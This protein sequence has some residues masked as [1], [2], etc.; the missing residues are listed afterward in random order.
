[1]RDMKA[2]TRTLTNG[3]SYNSPLRERQSE[4][5]REAILDA[6]ATELA[7][8][9]LQELNVPAVARRA[10]VAV[11]TVYRYFPTRDALLDAAEQRLDDTVAPGA[12]PASPEDLPVMAERVFREFDSNEKMILAQWATA[13]GRDVR[14]RGRRRRVSVYGDVLSTITS[15][16]PRA[17]ARAAHAI[18]SYLMSSWMW[19]TLR[20][21]FNMSG[22]QSGKAAAWALRV[23]ID[24]L[25]RRN[26]TTKQP[27][28]ATNNPQN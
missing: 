14:A 19:K 12:S 1:M 13:L 7:E 11:R 28:P 16:L 18:V 9:G 17:E 4:Q 26:E 15:D 6:L 5:T 3:R 25:K 22:A 2:P 10:G 8:G 20:E 27:N 21:E 24:D 23:L